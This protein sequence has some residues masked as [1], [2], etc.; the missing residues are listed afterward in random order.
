MG[1][2]TA[3]GEWKSFEGRMRQRRAQRLLLLA[4][5]AA[6]AGC[7]EDARAYLAEA[8]RLAPDLGGLAAVETKL[9]ART[10]TPLRPARL[11]RL[12]VAAAVVAA[13]MA[14]GIAIWPGPQRIAPTG[15]FRTLSLEVPSASGRSTVAVRV[16]S[17][18]PP[19]TASK[20]E[21]ALTDPAEREERTVPTPRLML[22]PVGPSPRPFL[23]PVGPIPVGDDVAAVAAAIESLPPARPLTTSPSVADVPPPTQTVVRRVLDRYAAAYSSLDAEAAA[24][25]WPRVDRAALASAFDALESQQIT[26]GDCRVDVSGEL[27]RA[28]CAGSASWVPKV[29]GADPHTESRRWTFDLARAG[30]DWQIVRAQTQNR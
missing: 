5:V 16:P 2:H 13:A 24:R 1:S 28:T 26:L 6:E 10:A 20:I 12:S 23:Q 17:L 7:P 25:V 21:R 8:R 9:P 3:T 22:Q 19:R 15:D 27:A 29:G 14:F 11:R 18:P 4:D 30:S